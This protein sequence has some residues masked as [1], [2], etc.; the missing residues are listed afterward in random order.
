MGQFRHLDEKAAWVRHLVFEMVMKSKRGHLPSSLSCVD[1][2]V[3][4][5]Y[6]HVLRYTAGN[7]SVDQRD[8]LVVSKGHAGMAVYPILADIGFI[9]HCE[10][11]KYAQAG[12]ALRMHADPSI[13]GVDSVGGSLGHGLGLAAGFA[14]A[15]KKD[16]RDQKSFVILGDAEC[17][18]GSVWET[19][20]FATHYQ[21]DNLIAVVDRNHLAILGETEALLKLEPLEGK[22]QS[23]GWNTLTADGHS[24]ESLL[25]AFSQI[26]KTQPSVPSVIIADTVKGKGISYME[27]RHEW[28]NR[29]PDE[30]L[31]EVAREEL[32]AYRRQTQG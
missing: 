17:Y 24:Y 18:E 32:T 3:A 13:P 6:G 19:A 10:F 25:G 26:S 15:A 4:L 30:K 11:G 21:L 9:D 28:H 8:R 5:Y 29:F 7:S 22:F 23:F 31:V 14:L 27:N 20:I 12:G 1:I 2:L 16:G